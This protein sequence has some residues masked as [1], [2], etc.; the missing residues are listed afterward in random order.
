MARRAFDFATAHPVAD[1]GFSTILSGLESDIASA[2]S[3]GMLQ[4]AGPQRQHVAVAQRSALKES[5]RSLQLSRLWRVAL[6]GSLM[7]TPN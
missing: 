6:L 2:D 5:I 1:S 7:R 3:L 4:A